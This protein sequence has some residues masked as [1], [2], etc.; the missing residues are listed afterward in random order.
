MSDPT[1]PLGVDVTDQVLAPDPQRRA[2]PD[3]T[4]GARRRRRPTGAPAPLPR[5]IGTSGKLWLVLLVVLLAWIPFALA[6]PAVLRFADR[7]DTAF[8]E[9]VARL[10]TDWLT[11]IMTRVDRVGSGWT[12]TVLAVGTIVL[13]LAFRRWRH[14]LTLLASVTVLEVVGSVIYT[15][16][17]RPRPYGVTIIGRWSGFSMPS[18]PV[19][20]LCVILI[21]VAY[22]LVV[23]GQPRTIAKWVVG[24]L[25]ALFVGSRLYLAVDHPSDVVVAVTFGV[26]IPLLAYRF[27]T[28]NEVFP[29]AYGKGKT[30][31]LDV[32]GRRGLAIRR[33]VQDQLGV[34]VTHVGHV[35]L[36]GSGGSTPIRMRVDDE[37]ETYLFAKL[38]AMNHV[39]SDRWYKLGR[40]ILYG[41]L[42]DESSFQTVRRLAEYEDYAARLLRDNG[43]PT[44]RSYGIVELTPEREYLLVTEFFDN[45]QEI[46]EADVDDQII[47]EA[48]M[49]VRRMWDAGLAHRD[50]KPA[51]LLVR[52][53]HVLVIDTAF[54][55]VRPSPWREAV[56]LANMM[57]VLAVR[58]DAPRVYAR[59]TQFF[60]EDE[61]A[62]AFAAARGVAS[63]SQLRAVMKADGRSLIEEFRALAPQRRPIALQRWS[64]RRVALALALVVGVV[65]AVAQTSSMLK[66]AHDVEVSATPDCGTGNLMIL[67]AQ[68]VPRATSVPCIASLPAGFKPGD[69]HVQRG[70]ASFSLDSDQGGDDAVK[71][72]FWPRS[73]CRLA[74]AQPVP[75]DEAGT[76]R[77]ER[78]ER[79]RPELT[80]TRTYLF[81]GGCAKYRY[82]FDRGASA[83]LLFA[84]DQALAFQDRASLVRAVDD[85]TDLRL[86]GAGVRCPGGTGSDG[87]GS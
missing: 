45:A 6:F 21:S 83:A 40:T 76:R 34:T 26:A 32:G 31:H 13:L 25:V 2:I 55:Q 14:L 67:M 68:A 3:A 61:I 64:V 52:D 81:P 37:P 9:Q 69:V 85:D 42:E 36:A 11:T 75:S 87:T 7:A 19:A 58:T 29:V 82:S 16:F 5:S 73:E 54:T 27:F 17:S 49:I 77:Y 65:F 12:L 79:L 18:P 60:T 50:I 70:H 1:R 10:R 28:P 24:V 48:L 62:E 4:D 56:D 33:A 86:C 46:G 72:S 53:G 30:A 41:R 8:L 51:N 63:P 80:G 23:P 66:P 38:Y 71:V 47:D 22:T 15:A 57:L 84:A 74:G 20:V 43:I 44:A 59:A 39:R 78:P 35:G